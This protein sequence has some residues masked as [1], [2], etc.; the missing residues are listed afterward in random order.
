MI[1]TDELNKASQN[2]VLAVGRP[3]VVG[4]VN[5]AG[6]VDVNE[7]DSHEWT[8]EAL[9]GYP[10]PVITITGVD[11]ITTGRQVYYI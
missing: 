11:G 1:S 4:W 5:V 6:S 3:A 2:L 10:E 9:G 7:G 8:C